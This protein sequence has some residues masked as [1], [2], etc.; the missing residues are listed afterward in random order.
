M[1][2]T[3]QGINPVT[4]RG[5]RSFTDDTERCLAIGRLWISA[6]SVR[7]GQHR[8]DPLNTNRRLDKTMQFVLYEGEDNILAFMLG[9]EMDFLPSMKAM[10]AGRIDRFVIDGTSARRAGEKRRVSFRRDPFGLTVEI[11][12]EQ[13]EALS[14]VLL[15]YERYCGGMGFLFPNGELK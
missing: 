5:T 11:V 2:T 3:K 7:D 1:A 15:D 8:F 12:N 13:G 10:L 4:I 14:T 9:D 6:N